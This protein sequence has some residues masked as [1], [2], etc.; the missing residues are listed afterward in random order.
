M[1]ITIKV[2]EEDIQKGTKSDSSCCP[3]ALACIRQIKKSWSEVHRLLVFLHP[4]ERIL[5]TQGIYEFIHK[6]DDDF[7]VEP[8]EFELPDY[9]KE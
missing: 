1:S 5:E 4:D 9:V 2:T 7:L 6:F 3:I 8:F